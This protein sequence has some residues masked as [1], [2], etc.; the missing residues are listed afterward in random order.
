ME[1]KEPPRG[2]QPIADAIRLFWKETGLRRASGDERVLRAWT[3]AAGAA[4]RSRATPCT[5]RGG[6]LTVEV[7]SS[8]HLAARK[9][10]HA[11]AIRAR[12]HAA[13][14]EARIH[15]GIFKLTS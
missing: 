9:G 10:D 1:R 3:D 12:A 6:H 14:G 13:R 15:K 8:G 11:E 7:A 5:F 4:W 2:P